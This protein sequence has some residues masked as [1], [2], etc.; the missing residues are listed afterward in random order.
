LVVVLNPGQR[1]QRFFLGHSDDVRCLAANPAPGM[2]DWMVSGQNAT[3]DEHGRSTAPHVCV[4]NSADVDG[5]HYKLLLPANARAVRCVTFTPCGQFIVAVANDDNHTVSIWDWRARKQVAEAKGDQNAI[6]QVKFAPTA[7]ADAASYEMFTVGVKH[8]FVWQW[9]KG[10]ASLKGK[11][12]ALSA[13]G[14]SPQTWNAITFTSTGSALLG[15]LDGNMLLVKAN[16]G[17]ATKSYPS[18]SAGAGKKPSAVYSLDAFDGGVV[19]GLANKS[20]VVYDNKMTAI[21]SF[22]FDFKVTSVWVRPSVSGSKDVLVG[23]QGGQVYELVGALDDHVAGGPVAG[24]FKPLSNGHMDGE[25]WAVAS[26]KDG[27]RAWTA[28]EDNQGQRS[29]LHSLY[30]RLLL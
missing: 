27:Q 2:Q 1:T 23:T 19:A 15:G 25:L 17:T 21:K 3:L 28:G 11:R 12:V 4:W 14:F 20:V 13:G 5:E 8:A 9:E 24:R 30:E 16:S 7:D 26:S 22:Q 10:S 6:L 29:N 18:T